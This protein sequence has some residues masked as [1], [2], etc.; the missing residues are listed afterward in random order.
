MINWEA[1]GAIGEVVGAVAVVI[2]IIYLALQIRQSGRIGRFTAHQTLSESLSSIMEPF[3]S[4][5]E[6]NH[7]WQLAEETPEQ[8]TPEQ[9]EQFG[10]VLYSVFGNFYNAYLLSEIDPDLSRRFVR[11][12]D[13]FLVRKGVQAWW[14]RQ[15]K[16]FPAGFSN[17][18]NKRLEAVISNSN[19]QAT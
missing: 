2:S 7:I 16:N 15:G 6:L 4:D 19:E 14:E 13:R 11:L 17:L 18:V 10:L 3:Y 9:R 5:P 12:M 1:I 8:M